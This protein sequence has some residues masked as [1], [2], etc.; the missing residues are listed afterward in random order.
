MGLS[1]DSCQGRGQA[2]F[3]CLI[4]VQFRLSK[5]EPTVRTQCSCGNHGQGHECCGWVLRESNDVVVTHPAECCD[6][7]L[8]FLLYLMLCGK[9]NPLTNLSSCFCE[10]G[11]A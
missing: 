6:F 1:R 8:Q 5:P 10:G 2:H 11:R 7:N 4:T 3:P 9:L